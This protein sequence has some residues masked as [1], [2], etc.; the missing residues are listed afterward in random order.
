MVSFHYATICNNGHVASTFVYDYIPYCEKC[1]EKTISDCLKCGTGIRGVPDTLNFPIHDYKAPSY[2]FSCGQAFPW[3]ETL[4]KNA[5][6]LISLDD[7]LSDEHKDIIKNALPDLI[8]EKPT[9]PVATAKYKK[10]IPG[11][12]KYIQD[13]LKN[14]L[15]DV[16]S[17]TVKKS[18]WD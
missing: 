6:K 12:A 8:V 11:A 14:L 7:N 2:C 1:G 16:V 4:I 18:L 17:E 15:V 9:S 3:T 13:G 5:V 10:F